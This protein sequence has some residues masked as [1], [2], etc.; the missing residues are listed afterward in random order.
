MDIKQAIG[1]VV[2]QQDLTEEEMVE[3]MNEIMGGEATPAQI[4]SFITGLRMKGETVEEITGAVRVMREKATSIDSGVDVM[5]G[6]IL[7]DTCG[8][9][10]DGSGTFNVSTTSAFVVA[11]AGLPVAKHGNRSVSSHC[12][13]ADVL[14]AAGVSL[15]LSPEEVGEC[16]Q[17]VG[18]GFL[19]APTL[20]G[21]M[22]HAIG[23]RR[24]IG[25]RTI[26]NILGP[27]TN[28]AGANVQVLGVF[29]RKLI[30][31]LALVLGKLGSKR[32]L[33]VHGEG[34][35]DE[36][37]ITGKTHIADLHN[38]QVTSYSVIPED[39]G[40]ARASLDELRGG[41]TAEESAAQMREVLAGTKGAK[42]DMVL[43]NS[44][45]ALMAAGLCADLK[46]GVVRAA[47]IIDSGRALDKLERLVTFSSNK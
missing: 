46:A 29:D 38:G 28:P 7:V 47:E 30:E 10:G 17:E 40:L 43:L 32:A 36:L 25:I 45:A 44:G 15:H 27:L 14:E 1:K 3:V 4:G 20:H 26:F 12:G 9:G 13:S 16:I 22:K 33:V 5:A 41:T 34:N 23:P 8:T 39:V 42:R 2:Q 24:E 21:A 31:P 37:T 35:L 19:F 18:I 6:G 11:G